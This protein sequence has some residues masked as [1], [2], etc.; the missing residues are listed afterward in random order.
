MEDNTPV[1]IPAWAKANLTVNEAA[2]YFGIGRAKI[3][4]LTDYEDCPYVLWCGNKRLIK[5]EPFTKYLNGLF[6]I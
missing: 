4:E 5:K 3:R 2:A 6:S 1:S